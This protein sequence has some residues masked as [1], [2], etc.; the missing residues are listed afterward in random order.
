LH[1]LQVLELGAGFIIAIQLIGFAFLLSSH[2]SRELFAT[3]APMK[4][5]SLILVLMAT[6]STRP[7]LQSGFLEIIDHRLHKR[8]VG[9][10]FPGVVFDPWVSLPSH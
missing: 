9:S 6:L 8:Q 4:L 2:F 5:L 1:F 7:F 3:F 10:G